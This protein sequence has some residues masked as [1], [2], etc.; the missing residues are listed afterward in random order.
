M[1]W[2]KHREVKQE[3]L[4]KLTDTAKFAAVLTAVGSRDDELIAMALV[5]VAHMRT[6]Q[7]TSRTKQIPR[8]PSTV[9][10]HT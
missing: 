10:T 8:I 7:M 1:R 6:L 4:G 3:E 9:C 5:N 2:C